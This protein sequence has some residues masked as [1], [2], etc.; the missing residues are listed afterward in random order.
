MGEEIGREVFTEADR[1][2]FRARLAEETALLVARCRAGL[3]GEAAAVGGWELEAWLVDA[4]GRPAPVNEALLARARGLPLCP[5]LARFNLELNGEARP[6]RGRALSAIARDLDKTWRAAAEAARE[7]GAR[8]AM[9]GT[10]PSAR[11]DDFGPQAMSPLRR[12]RAL[13]AEVMRLRRG[14]PV[15]VEI[16][17]RERL[18][19]ARSDLM[20]EAASTSF[21]IHLQVE[22]AR[23]GDLYNAAVA[24]SGPMVAACAN[25]PFLFGRELWAETRIPLFEQAVAVGGPG[26][27]DR[28]TLGAGYLE[29]GLEGLFQ[30]N[31]RYPVLLPILFDAPPERFAHLRLHNGTIWR[32][33]RPLVGFDADGRLRLRVEHRVVPAGPTVADAVANAAL[34]FGLAHRLAA[35]GPEL[36]RRLPFAAARANL[37]AAARHG[38]A[39][40]LRWLDGREREARALWLEELL[41]LAHEGL[42]RLGLDGADAAAHLAVVEARLQRRRTGADWQ[43]AWVA[44]HGADMVR[45]TEA[46]LARQDGGAPVCEWEV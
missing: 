2:A 23:A 21:Q 18:R 42:A 26:S 7:L 29:G 36:A 16:G 46:Y 43:R 3:G 9:I 25:A 31:L 33:N 15:V 34:F 1:E 41:P 32:W 4:A 17:G 22:A 13:N 24:A 40:R 14:R 12:Y 44:R 35:L 27:P 19:C 6:L 45:L 30:E 8:L 28:V 5:E 10:L 39:A 20:L 11:P 37:Y 38:L